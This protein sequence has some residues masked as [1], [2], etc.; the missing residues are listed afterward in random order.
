MTR[1]S[2]GQIE[3]GLSDDARTTWLKALVRARARTVLTSGGV[4]PVMDG[5]GGKHS[6]F[7]KAFLEVLWDNDG[8]LEAQRL[9]REV[10]ARVV[11]LAASF[12]VEQRPEYAP[13]K[14]AGHESGDFIFVPA[15]S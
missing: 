5:G 9:Y 10:A 15:G 1:S 7:A 12:K 4:Q 8:A 3:S 6:I 11:Y 13:L 2:I 14:F